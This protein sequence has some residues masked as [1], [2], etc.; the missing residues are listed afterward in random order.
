MIDN[1]LY[2]QH[3]GLALLC[4][5]YVGRSYH[6]W[7]A[8]ELLPW[9]EKNANSVV[10]MVDRGDPVVA[11]A[12]AKRSKRY[13]GVPRNVHRHVIMSDIPDATTSLPKVI[14]LKESGH[15]G[16]FLWSVTPGN[17]GKVYKILPNSVLKC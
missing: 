16:V 12:D 7:K 17:R 11:A 14:F 2:R 10:S 13:Q 8:P 3:P 5:L 9:L 15:I 1:Y 4:R 6:V